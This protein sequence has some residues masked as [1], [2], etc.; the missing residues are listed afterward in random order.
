VVRRSARRAVDALGVGRCRGS[1]EGRLAVGRGT[2]G[3]DDGHVI[4][5]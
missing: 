5:W 1:H 2:G 4:M 3:G